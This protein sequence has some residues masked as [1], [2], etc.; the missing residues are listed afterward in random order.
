MRYE[1]YHDTATLPVRKGQ[2]IVIP[3]GVRV[4]S[5]NPRKPEY[6]TKRRQ[7]VTVRMVMCGQS[8]NYHTALN[9]RYYRD[10]LEKRGFDFTPLQA[11]YE[12]NTAEYYRGRVAITNPSIAWA[13]EGGYW[14]D[15]D[16][17]DVLV[18]ETGMAA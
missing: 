6:V 13:G 15:V 8:V 3:A 18:D 12:N 9:D 1:G 17:N 16:I 5:M 11:A 2:T 7:T 14:C 4:K 10:P